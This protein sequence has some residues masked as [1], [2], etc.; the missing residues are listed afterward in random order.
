V[1]QSSRFPEWWQLAADQRAR[2]LT[3]AATRATRLNEYLHAFV[4]VCPGR[5]RPSIGPLALL[6]YAAKDLFAAPGH[7]PCAGLA[8]PLG[9]AEG[10]AEA[11]WRLDAA[12]ATRIGF[13][14][15]T[16]LAYEPSGYNSSSPCPRNP[17]HLDFV[18]GGSS[19]GSAVAVASDA[20]VV[21]FGSDTGGSI[22]IPAHCCGVTGWKPTWGTVSAAGAMPL[23]PFLDSIGLLARCAADLSPA[24]DILLPVGGQSADIETLAVIGDAMDETEPPVRRACQDGLD[25]C[26]SLSLRLLKVNALPV[27][28][29]VDQ[30][31][32]IVMQ[33]E[34]ARSHV[35]RLDDPTIAAVLRK[36]LRKGLEIDDAKLDASRA[37]RAQLVEQFEA[38]VLHGADAAV[39]P[40]MPVRTPPYREVDPT[41]PDFSARGLYA[42]SR[43]C[44]FVNMLGL[45][46]VA[47]PV[48]FDDRGL[49]VAMQIVGRGGRDRDLIRLAI[50]LQQQSDWHGRVPAV[51]RDLVCSDPELNT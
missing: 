47:V 24:A 3:I 23:A 40:V 45:P 6:P 41:S 10:Y 19:S 28:A 36:R 18:P 17:W 39:L 1:V 5:P 43:F 31:A 12:G 51:I 22:R 50:R 38:Q 27:I 4:E 8:T 35:G 13:T 33:G 9:M 21:A 2:H 20:A 25:L 30:H 46:A 37:V 29:A 32:L 42:L 15:M 26:G 48:G 7:R 14:A 49:P 34:A 16:E 11:L 44:R